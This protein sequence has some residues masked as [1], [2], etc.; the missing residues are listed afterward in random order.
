MTSFVRS[1]RYPRH[2]RS[3]SRR[4]AVDRQLAGRPRRPQESSSRGAE[5]IVRPVTTTPAA[6]REPPATS[7]RTPRPERSPSTWPP[8]TH[9]SPLEAVAMTPTSASRPAP[10]RLG[11]ARAPPSSAPTGAASHEPPALED[12]DA[13]A[14]RLDVLATARRQITIVCAAAQ[15]RR[16]RRARS[17]GPRGRASRTARRGAGRRVADQRLRDRQPPPLGGW[18]ERCDPASRAPPTPSRSAAASTAAR[19]LGPLHAGEIRRERERLPAR[20]S[21]SYSC[22]SLQEH[23]E[24]RRASMPACASCDLGNEQRAAR[25]PGEPGKDSDDRRLAGAGR[26]EEPEGRARRARRGRRRR[27]PR[28]CRTAWSGPAPRSRRA[29]HAA[30]TTANGSPRAAARDVGRAS[31]PC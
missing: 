10:T 3:A 17:S 16:G 14:R 15:R 13:V 29:I 20:S 19:M 9:G 21:S 18:R 12:R 30:I 26:P 24:P 27:A 25:R 22:A 5:P 4:T 2:S 11:A 6:A 23:A 7:S 28:P 1:L 8:R 31:R